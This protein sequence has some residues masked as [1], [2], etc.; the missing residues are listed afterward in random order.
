MRKTVATSFSAF[1]QYLMDRLKLFPVL[2]YDYD[3]PVEKNFKQIKPNLVEILTG[4]R[5]CPSV[6]IRVVNTWDSDQVKDYDVDIVYK[7]GKK[8]KN[9]GI[10]MV[11]DYLCTDLYNVKDAYHWYKLRLKL[12]QDATRQLTGK[13]S[14]GGWGAEGDGASQINNTI[15]VTLDNMADYLP[16][17]LRGTV[18]QDFRFFSDFNMVINSG[19]VDPKVVEWYD[20]WERKNL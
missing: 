3:Y 4:V 12:D 13:Y 14:K 15:D 1:Q 11:E 17:W 8:R 7:N 5:S 20:D 18:Y 2:D 19:S 10:M 16:K 9:V 6:Q